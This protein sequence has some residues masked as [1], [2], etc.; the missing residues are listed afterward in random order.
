MQNIFLKFILLISSIISVN[1]AL[2]IP[3]SLVISS[4]TQQVEYTENRSETLLL[5]IHECTK[6]KLADVVALDKNSEKTLHKASFIR[7]VDDSFNLYKESSKLINTLEIRQQH[8][9]QKEVFQNVF[10]LLHFRFVSVLYQV[11]RTYLST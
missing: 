4:D 2:A 5:A 8:I 11:E 6:K 10:V 7:F 1:A 9:I 3:L